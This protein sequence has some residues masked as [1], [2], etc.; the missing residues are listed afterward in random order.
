MW[1]YFL[2]KWRYPELE[3]CTKKNLTIRSETKNEVLVTLAFPIEGSFVTATF[4][5]GNL[6]ITGVVWWD[7]KFV[8]DFIFFEYQVK[9]QHWIRIKI[10]KYFVWGSFKVGDYSDFAS[11]FFSFLFFCVCMCVYSIDLAVEIFVVIIWF[12]DSNSGYASDVSVLLGFLGLSDCM[13]F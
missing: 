10:Y 12:N 6:P 8:A 3:L 9:R 13:L 1:R 2:W 7:E 11:F 4:I 5:N